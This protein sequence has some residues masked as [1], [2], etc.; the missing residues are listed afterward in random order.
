MIHGDFKALN[1]FFDGDGDGDGDGNSGGE[2]PC[3]VHRVIDWQWAGVGI[4]LS[5]VAQHLW[6][7]VAVDAI[8]EEGLLRHYVNECAHLS[9]RDGDEARGLQHDFGDCI[10]HYKLCV[11]DFARMVIARFL[12]GASPRTFRQKANMPNV[13]LCYRSEPCCALFVAR[14]DDLLSELDRDTDLTPRLSRLPAPG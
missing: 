12:A 11:L 2:A 14:V 6:H 7:S 1:I 5:D 3:S 4:G 10:R 8:D 13:G 9:G